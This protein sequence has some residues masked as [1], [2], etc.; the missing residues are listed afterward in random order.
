MQGVD[1]LGTNLV[2]FHVNHK[3][4]NPGKN[5]GRTKELPVKNQYLLGICLV[6][7][8]CNKARR[9]RNRKSDTES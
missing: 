1:I 5:L 3:A 6:R 7:N 2:F 9:Q 4:E 8:Q